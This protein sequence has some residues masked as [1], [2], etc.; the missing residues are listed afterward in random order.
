MF[1]LVGVG[2]F[3]GFVLTA[4]IVF[5]NRLRT[6]YTLDDQ[7]VT[8][9]TRDRTSGLLSRLAV[10]A[11]AIGGQP[12]TVGAGLL[13]LSRR[14]EHLD[15]AGRFTLHAQP[16]A[17]RLILRNRWRALMEVDCTPE[18][19]A[20]IEALVRHHM[21]PQRPPS[22]TEAR[23]PLPR[24]LGHSALILLAAFV[25][26][27][28]H[29]EFGLDLFAPMLL[30]TFALATL[31]L[32]PLFGYVVLMINA[33]ILVSLVAASWEERRSFIQ[34]HEHYR[35]YEVFSDADWALLSFSLLAL[36]YLTWLGWRAARGR[37]LSLLMRDQGDQTRST[38]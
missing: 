37:L 19:F 24:Y 20:Q 11:G 38:R 12:G 6:R 5:G 32:I 26:F 2:L 3:V 23:S 9:E 30:V 25:L 13:A 8:Q 29:D 33:A 18:N 28:A 27:T 10:R 16:R 14:H 21:S 7:G 31:W 22:R 17:H 15:W 35:H 36:G 4:L 1:A 34:L